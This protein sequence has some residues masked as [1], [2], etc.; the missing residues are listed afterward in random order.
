MQL[1]KTP[2][3]SVGGYLPNTV[4][5]T[6]D[7][8]RDFAWLRLPSSPLGVRSIV[9][10][11]GC[12]LYPPFCVAL[13]ALFTTSTMPQIT[14]VSS[15]GYFYAYGI[16]LG[17]GGE[18]TLTKQF[19]LLESGGESSSISITDHP[20]PGWHPGFPMAADSSRE[21]KRPE[22]RSHGQHRSWRMSTAK[23]EA[24]FSTTSPATWH[25]LCL[26]LP[27]LLLHQTHLSTPT[28]P[29]VVLSSLSRISTILIS[30][31]AYETYA[32]RKPKTNPQDPEA[33]LL[34]R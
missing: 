21:T 8:P 32:E 23:R 29:T 28:I 20:R 17:K 12:I 11:S 18:C 15:E 14:V 1:S 16:D 33:R 13:A 2:T 30:D 34:R 4:A 9:G 3:H 25:Y 6:W 5:E 19:S 24:C 31:T 27:L 7:P 26:T 22:R 10:L